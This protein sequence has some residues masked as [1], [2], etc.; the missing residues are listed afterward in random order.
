MPPLDIIML[1]VFQEVS[2]FNLIQTQSCQTIMIYSN[3]YK[4]GED[5]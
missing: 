4:E 3:Y 1:S 5:L 2:D